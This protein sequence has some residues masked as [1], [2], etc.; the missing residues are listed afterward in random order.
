MDNQSLPTELL[1]PIIEHLSDHVPS[2]LSVSLAS[3]ALRVEGQRLLF[4]TVAL[5]KD[6]KTHITFLTAITTSSV[7]APLVEEYQQVG[8]LDAEHKQEPLWGLTCRALQAMVNLKV[9]LFRALNGHPSVQILQECTFQLE[10]FRWRSY[11]DAEQL[12]KFFISQPNLRILRADWKGPELNTSG[13]C[14]GLQVL[15]GNRGTMNR[16]LPGRSIT[17]LKWSPDQNESLLNSSIDHLS[18]EFHRIRFFSFG[19]Q[20]GRPW[21]SLVIPHLRALEV[22]ELIGLNFHEVRSTFFFFFATTLLISSRS[23]IGFP[24]FPNYGCSSFPIHRTAAGV[25]YCH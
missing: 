10:V 20:W 2:L 11:D 22:F 5:Q 25:V 21:L 6:K 18:Q 16:F 23:S 24:T 7:L 17:S 19:G 9:F 1:R 15:H 14:L 4:R 8:L 12:L 3:P 13:V